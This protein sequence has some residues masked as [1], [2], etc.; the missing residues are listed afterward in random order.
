MLMPVEKCKF[1]VLKGITVH[2]LYYYYDYHHR[3][4]V[5]NSAEV[6]QPRTGESLNVSP[7]VFCSAAILSTLLSR[8]ESV[9]RTNWLMFLLT[10]SG[11]ATPVDTLT[12]NTN[13]W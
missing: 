3:R 8:H 1:G 13:C 9:D 11:Q 7:F 4:F 10:P 6:A 12:K 2:M 5:L